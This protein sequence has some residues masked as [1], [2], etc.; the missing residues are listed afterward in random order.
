MSV[1]AT[2]SAIAGK[3]LFKKVVADLYNYCSTSG[4]VTL[5]QW[6]TERQM[7]TLYRRISSVRKVKTIWQVDKT[8][9]LGA[10][11]CDSHVVINDKRKKV[12]QLSDFG[13]RDN[14]VIQGI[15]GQGKSIFLRYLCS[16]ELARGQ[17]IP[18]FLELRRIS[19]DAPLMDRIKHAF[20]ALNLSVDDNLFQLLASSGK[21]ILLLDAFDEVPDDLK[22]KVLTD[23]EDLSEKYDKLKIVVTSRPNHCIQL[24][25]QFSVVTLANLKDSEYKQVIYKLASGQAWA[26]GLVEHIEKKATHIKDLLCTP[27]MVTLLVIS[28][29]SYQKLPAKLSDF[30]DAL[31]QT[32]LQRHDGTKPGFT[33][34]RGC[35]L[36]DSEYRQVFETLCILIKKR[37]DRLLKGQLI[38]DVTKKAIEQCKLTASANCYV[39]DIVKITC[40]LI[41]DG[42]EYR[43]IHK[44]VQEYYTATYIQKKPDV[45]AINFYSR[46]YNSSVSREWHQE[47]E[48]LSEIDSYRYN[49]YFMLPA[50]L[51]FLNLSENNIYDAYKKY[52]LSFYKDILSP[53]FVSLKKNDNT[54][55]S[56][57]YGWMSD[58]NFIQRELIHMV[59]M[60]CY[61]KIEDEMT[62]PDVLQK[63]V[64]SSEDHNEEADDVVRIPIIN[65]FNII[66]DTLVSEI[67]SVCINYLKNA[68]R[69]YGDL[70]DDENPSILDD[71]I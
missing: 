51:K 62:K 28:Y 52:S 56:I 25:N 29:K 8:V 16:Q 49:R 61:K 32:L 44:T 6:S 33:R 30:Y 12:V 55:E 4:K 20:A 42:E 57:Q 71:L 36:D 39:D 70:R 48:F 2:A 37:S 34:Q 1:L 11:Y 60:K 65:M 66:G 35:N 18:L 3:E 43:F 50:I 59:I 24:S 54:T 47:L 5:K 67:D 23:I 19:N 9:D 26:Q 13:T 40:L 14:I 7:E 15:A 69:I 58:I 63:I 64:V 22:T 10:F 31:F 41:K 38:Y 53:V 46:I 17:F 68:Q 27:L 21:L 45:W